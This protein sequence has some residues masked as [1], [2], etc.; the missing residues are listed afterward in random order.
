MQMIV[1]ALALVAF[2]AAAPA[3][4]KLLKSDNVQQSDGAYTYE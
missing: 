1:V 3:E 2:A 4:V